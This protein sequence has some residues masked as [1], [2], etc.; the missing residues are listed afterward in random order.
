V[1]QSN[2]V[3]PLVKWPPP[4]M[5]ST[6]TTTTQPVVYI[7]VLSDTLCPPPYFQTGAHYKDTILKI[8]KNIPRK[9]TARGLRP[10][11][12]IL[13]VV[14]DLYISTTGLPILLTGKY[15]DQSWEYMNRSQTHEYGIV[16]EA[17]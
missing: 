9:G 16:T 7:V 11:F 13:V 14:S 5:E 17:T 2:S 15:A 12:H 4:K 1:L 6:N 8:R 10:N 3:V